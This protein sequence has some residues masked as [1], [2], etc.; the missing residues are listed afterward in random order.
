MSGVVMIPSHACFDGTVASM[1]IMRRR[2][3]VVR[4]GLSERLTRG[5]A[6][7]D[8]LHNAQ[9]R[10]MSPAQWDRQPF[11]TPPPFVLCCDYTWTG[12]LS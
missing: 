10:H 4:R 2:L 5:S 12:N 1:S 7:Q 3:C 9:D 6:L 11:L 8:L